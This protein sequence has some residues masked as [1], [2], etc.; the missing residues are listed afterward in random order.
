MGG[1][2]PLLALVAVQSEVLAIVHPLLTL[3]DLGVVAVPDDL[4]A[5]GSAGS[6]Y[7]GVVA[8]LEDLDV[9]R[10]V[11]EVK[12]GLDIP[13]PLGQVGGFSLVLLVVPLVLDVL[14][15]AL[16]LREEL[17]RAVAVG[18]RVAGQGDAVILVR[19]EDPVAVVDT[20][21]CFFE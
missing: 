15:D 18:V 11:E 12:G 5:R 14:R 3:D 17:G 6:D 2:D 8:V 10:R 9:G 4:D 7:L 16:P 1:D 20:G 13:P 21:V 19:G